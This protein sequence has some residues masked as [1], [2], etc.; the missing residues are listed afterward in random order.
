V[1]TAQCLHDDDYLRGNGKLS[2]ID[3]SYSGEWRLSARDLAAYKAVLTPHFLPAPL[4]GGVNVTW[5]GAGSAAKHE[6]KFTAR[7]NRFHLLGPGGT[8]PLDA[9]CNGSYRPGSLQIEKLRLAEDGTS[10]TGS[11]SIGPGAVNIRDLR[12]QHQNR[13]WLQGDACL[14]LDLWQRW[15]DVNFA[16]LLNAETVSSIHLTAT[17]LDLRQTSRLTGIDWPL[18]GTI[19]GHVDADGTLGSLN[20][21]G[22]VHLVRGSVPLDWQGTIIRDVEATFML[23]GPSIRLDNAAGKHAGG[24][25]ML[26]GRLDLTKPRNPL[27]VAEGSGTHQSEPFRFILTGPTANPA[28]A[29]QGAAPFPGTAAAPPP[30]PTAVAN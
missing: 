3:G 12:V 14:P 30:Q 9:E 23:E 17:D 10:L 18:R 21:A 20:L 11:A 15:P 1:I 13:V 22:S 5:A 16:R 8:L 6:G 4:G 28:I 2:L 26:A 29:T 24:D 27:I 19:A 7:L 25:F